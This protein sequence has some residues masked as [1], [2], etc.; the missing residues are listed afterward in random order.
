MKVKVTFIRTSITDMSLWVYPADAIHQMVGA[1]V[2]SPARKNL[3][4][5]LGHFDQCITIGHSQRTKLPL[6][7]IMSLFLDSNFAFQPVVA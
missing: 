5:L 7:H 2:G 1:F 4:L 6:Q 3:C